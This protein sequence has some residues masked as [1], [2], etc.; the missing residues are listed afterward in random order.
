M[1][2]YRL[3]STMKKLIQTFFLIIFIYFSVIQVN[4]VYDFIDINNSQ[5]YV[6]KYSELSPEYKKKIINWEITFTIKNGSPLTEF[7]CWEDWC[8][9]INISQSSI[10]DRWTIIIH[11]N[12]SNQNLYLPYKIHFTKPVLALDKKRNTTFDISDS[13]EIKTIQQRALSCEISATAD[14]LSHLLQKEITENT[15]LEKLKKS[16]YNTLPQ[17][18]NNK[19]Y[20]GNPQEGFVWY[21]DTTSNWSVARQRKMTGY[22]V[23]EDPIVEIIDEYGLKSKVITQE[24]YLPD[25]TQKQHLTYILEELKEWNMVQLWWDICTNPKYYNWEENPCTYNWKPSWDH[26]R[27]LTWY[28]KDSLWNDVLHTWL[29]GEH[30]YYLLWY[31]WHI[32]NPTHIIIWDT[33]TGKHTYVTSEWMRKWK[34][35]QYRSIIVYKK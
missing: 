1:L 2:F 23:L 25:F 14:I 8:F 5:R 20:W 16:E 30:A 27:K 10:R 9:F 24:N 13:M 31:K 26:P 7:H 22:W 18:K 19:I 3:Y 32:N 21:I 28:Y 17:I 33:Y 29:N 12:V 35:M 11:N 6:I 34:K 4:S 15:L